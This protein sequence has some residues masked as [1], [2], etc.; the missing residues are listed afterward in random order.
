M[1]FI[2][3]KIAG[4]QSMIAYVPSAALRIGRGTNA[5]LRL[6]D[7]AVALE[8]AVIRWRPREEL[9]ASW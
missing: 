1:P 5:E 4:Q 6:D 2:V 8:H 7:I 3:Q 9:D